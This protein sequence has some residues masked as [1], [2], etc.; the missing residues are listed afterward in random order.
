VGGKVVVM[1]TRVEID[2][3]RQCLFLIRNNKVVKT[4]AVSTGKPGWRTPTGHFS[5]YRK[6]PRWHLSSLGLLYK[7]CFVVGGI[8]IHGAT[9]VPRYPASHGCIRVT[10]GAMNSLY[11]ELSL[12]TQVYIHH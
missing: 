12:G 4:L 9:S 2:L 11:P 1:S 5:V 7:P 3:T 6:I 8:A 10:L